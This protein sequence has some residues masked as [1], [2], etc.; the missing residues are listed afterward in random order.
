MDVSSVA[1]VIVGVGVV[2][3]L[4]I[5]LY[6]FGWKWAKLEAKVSESSKA[7]KEGKVE[8]Q[9]LKD[10]VKKIEVNCAGCGAEMKAL[11]DKVKTLYKTYVIDAIS[12]QRLKDPI[13]SNPSLP[14]GMGEL[15]IIDF[16]EYPVGKDDPEKTCMARVTRILTSAWEDENGKVGESMLDKIGREGL[17]P[18]VWSLYS[19]I[20]TRNECGECFLKCFERSVN[21]VLGEGE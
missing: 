12:R 7:L 8:L 9:G 4:G 19:A 18:V 2:V 10:D 14:E 21:K 11:A 15:L 6:G 16:E 17:Y 3:N 5:L 1:T 13:E 20:R